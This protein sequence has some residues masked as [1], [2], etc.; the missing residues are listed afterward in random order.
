M[1]SRTDRTDRTDRTRQ[2]GFPL[3]LSV[4]SVLL[5]P[6]FARAGEPDLKKD[7]VAHYPFDKDASD[8]SGNG[9]DATAR[10]ARP[11]AAGRIGEAFAFNGTSDHVVV[12]PKATTGLTWFTLALWFRTTQVAASPR[13]RFWSN[14][15]LIGASTGG[16][17]SNDLALMLENGCLAYF[18]GLQAEGT[19]TTWWSSQRVADDKWHHVA[20]VCEGQR[21][22]LYL[23]G[24]LARGEVVRYSE[25]GQE[26]LGEQ[27]QT[28][29]G[30]A[31]GPAALFIGANNEGG[32]NYGFKGLIDDVRIWNRAL[33]ADEVADLSP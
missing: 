20:L 17:G 18:H 13:S 28:A 15:T 23:D 30:N 33:S 29:A 14:P 11:V 21:V 4:L 7:L 19:D 22:R 25:N 5:V 27:A 6:P 9:H 12:P 31:L 32:A 2:R 10:G 16:W 1:K 3:A 8:A 26:S 24:K